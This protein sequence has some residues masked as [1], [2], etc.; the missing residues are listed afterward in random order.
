MFRFWLAWDHGFGSV[1]N[2]GS[3]MTRRRSFG[4]L[5]FVGKRTALLRRRRPRETCVCRQQTQISRS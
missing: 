3:T 2:Q 1:R 5:R 4:A